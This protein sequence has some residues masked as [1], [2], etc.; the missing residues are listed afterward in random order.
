MSSRFACVLQVF[1]TEGL[2]REKERKSASS[3]S[4]SSL[5]STATD[6]SSE[7]IRIHSVTQT[8]FAQ[9]LSAMSPALVYVKYRQGLDRASEAP[10]TEEQLNKIYAH[11]FY[12]VRDSHAPMNE[13]IHVYEIYPSGSWMPWSSAIVRQLICTFRLGNDSTSVTGAAAQHQH[14]DNDKKSSTIIDEKDMVIVAAPFR[15]PSSLRSSSSSSSVVVKI[16]AFQEELQRTIANM[17]ARRQ[18]RV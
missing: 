16:P 6:E 18:L 1:S 14:S 17:Q 7:T 11:G 15:T 12:L 8:E 5:S 3:V 4:P 13:K 10:L 9:G 2:Q